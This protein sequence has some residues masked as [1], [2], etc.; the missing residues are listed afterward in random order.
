MDAVFLGTLYMWPGFSTSVST[1]LMQR[2]PI[3]VDLLFLCATGGHRTYRSSGAAA[4]SVEQISA[5]IIFELVPQDPTSFLRNPTYEL[6]LTDLGET[7]CIADLLK[8]ACVD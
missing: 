4:N 7:F 2:L 5:E 6:E 1:S 3:R 8:Y